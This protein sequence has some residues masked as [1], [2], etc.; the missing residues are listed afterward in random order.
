M[1]SLADL[2]QLGRFPS[3]RFPS[4]SSV[5]KYS[6]LGLALHIGANDVGDR[7]DGMDA[8]LL[9]FVESVVT[10]TPPPAFATTTIG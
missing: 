4:L 7:W 3:T 9:R 8:W 6:A 2:A 5:M 10:R 1:S